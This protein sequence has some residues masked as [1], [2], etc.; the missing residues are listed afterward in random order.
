[1]NQRIPYGRQS[2]DQDDIDQV[3]KIL[4][5]DF[6]TQGPVIDRFEKNLLLFSKRKTKQQSPDGAVQLTLFDM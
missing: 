1:M 5:S 2:I 4:Q 6:I 3:I